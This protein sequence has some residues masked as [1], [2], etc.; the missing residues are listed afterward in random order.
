MK[1]IS[2]PSSVESIGVK[3]F[4]NCTKLE[5]VS[6]G[7]ESVLATIGNHCF[8]HCINLRS[9]ELPSQIEEISSGL[10]EECSKL[11]SITISSD[12]SKIGNYS[13]LNCYN[14]DS[15]RYLGIEEPNVSQNAF[16]GCTKIKYVNVTSK[17]SSKTF[18]PFEARKDHES[19]QSKIPLIVICS[20]IFI[21]VCIIILFIVLIIKKKCMKKKSQSI[22]AIENWMLSLGKKAKPKMVS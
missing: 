3:A 2:I 12:V 19:N 13:F 14:L 6:F 7:K 21:I 15:I 8:S 20:V 11:K 1:S 9:I 4:C 10:F 22:Q 18:G 5:S 17:Y 16:Q